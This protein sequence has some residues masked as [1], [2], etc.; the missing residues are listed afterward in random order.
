MFV[1]NGISNTTIVSGRQT[2]PFGA[3]EDPSLLQ[4]L[5]EKG[6]L[7]VDTLSCL[8]EIWGDNIL[9]GRQHLYRLV[10]GKVSDAEFQELLVSYYKRYSAF[11]NYV[12]EKY[13][14]GDTNIPLV[15]RIIKPARE[16]IG[17]YTKTVMRVGRIYSGTYLGNHQD[18]VYLAFTSDLLPEFDG[19]CRLC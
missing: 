18:F 2:T 8:K 17:E 12:D 10:S 4:G 13:L 15:T 11:A 6:V 14:F 1:A 16:A 19:G 5:P 7:R 3:V 9:M